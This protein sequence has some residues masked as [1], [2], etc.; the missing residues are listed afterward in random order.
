MLGRKIK[1]Q[2][3]K[4]NM[5]KAVANALKCLYSDRSW[6]KFQKEAM[7]GVFCNCFKDYYPDFPELRFKKFV[8]GK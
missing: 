1:K 3:H 4:D 8:R 6:S 5:G 2:M 7:L